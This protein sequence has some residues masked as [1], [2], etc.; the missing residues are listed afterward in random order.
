MANPAA[1]RGLRSLGGKERP[2]VH[3]CPDPVISHGCSRLGP[4]PRTQTPMQMTSR[5]LSNVWFN[6]SPVS[7]CVTV[8]TGAAVPF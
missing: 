5:T 8:V 6:V 3:H 4:P 1:R 2:A 7:A